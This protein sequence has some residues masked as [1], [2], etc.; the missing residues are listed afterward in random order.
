MI[1]IDEMS[2]GL[3]NLLCSKVTCKHKGKVLNTKL[4]NKCLDNEE[5]IRLYI[6]PPQK[7]LSKIKYPSII[8]QDYDIKSSNDR[9][10]TDVNYTDPNYKENIIK[11]VKAGDRVD[12]YFQIDFISE[13]KS[14]IVEMEANWRN[15]VRRFGSLE[16]KEGEVVTTT[17]MSLVDYRSLDKIGNEEPDNRLFRRSFSYKIWG[18]MD[19]IE[20]VL[21]L[22]LSVDVEVVKVC[23]QKL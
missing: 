9:I 16:V 14:Q 10:N 8:V 2:L 4:F 1:F 18:K 6:S 15:N 22:V 23:N 3:A 5:A 7:E 21:K 17:P 20:E 13:Y 11:L 19:D 12:V